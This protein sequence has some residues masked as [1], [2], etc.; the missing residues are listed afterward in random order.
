MNLFSKI[1]F[2]PSQLVSL[3]VLLT[4]LLFI[5]QV[6]LNWQTYNNFNNITQQEFQLQK[7]SDQI[8]YLDEV[9]TMSARMNAATGNIFW[10]KRYREFE[11]QLDAAIQKS[12]QLA[13]QTY[14]D[15]NSQK[16]DAA[17]QNLVAMEYESFNL[18]NQNQ[19]AAAQ[20]LL[21]SQE[22]E[23]HKQIYADGVAQ[24]NLNISR[25]LQTKVIACRQRMILVIVISIIS[26]TILFPVWYLVLR[27]L[28]EYLIA[29][30][31]AQAALEQTNYMLE[32]KVA[33]R[34]KKLK[35]K[36]LQ[37]QKTLQDLRQTQVQLIQTEKMSSLA[38][39]VAGIAHE[40]NNPINFISGNLIHVR[41]Y[42]SKL[43]NLINYY[44]EKYPDPH[45][46]ITNFAEEIDLNFIID[47]LPNILSSMSSGANRIGEIVLNLRNF[48]RLDEA[49][50]KRV[51]IH[52]GLDSTILLLQAGME[53][54][55]EQPQIKI[56]KEY[57]KLPLVE[58]YPRGLN[59][60]FMNIIKNAIEA[61]NV[62]TTDAGEKLTQNSHSIIIRTAM[63]NKNRVIIAIKDT[64]KGITEK[65]QK[66]L[67]EPFFT[68]K[69][70]GKG[71]G[72]GL[73]ISYQIIVD[74]HNG[75]IEFV[76][77]LGKGTEFL[78]DIPI[79]QT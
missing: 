22:Y 51:N 25:S 8:L 29:K 60:V 6:W 48:S 46:Q 38:Q 3:T 79:Q 64:G 62:E 77:E 75:N 65:L 40:I 26:L 44:Q 54:K 20:N 61:V 18:V 71:T 13:P 74:K 21:S 23:F 42:T 73:S 24:R 39:L 49:E 59:Q 57:G 69:P 52:E 45:P 43:V 58:C 28:Q 12:M 41:D 10:E 67:F 72:L 5:P 30:N 36:N 78:I 70:V 19:K 16:I 7:I 17:N 34:T 2:T 35:Q 27:L 1:K 31:K 63:K 15:E 11:P 14:E 4:L 66:R 37:L 33:A 68:T 56:I 32:I 53:N 47:D 9:L 76:S 50:M 55:H